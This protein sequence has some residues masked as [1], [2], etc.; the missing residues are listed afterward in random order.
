MKYFYEKNTEFIESDVNKTFEQVLWMSDEEFR[1]W[2]HDMRDLVVKLWDEKGQPP[3]VGYNER[4]IIDQFNKL[5]SF[6]VSL[7][8]LKIIQ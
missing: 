8:H 7:A 3:R 5:E 4:E 6:P 2:L 1:Q